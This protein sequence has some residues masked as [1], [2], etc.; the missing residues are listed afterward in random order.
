MLTY[1]CYVSVN[2]SS[3]IVVNKCSLCQQQVELMLYFIVMKNKLHDI[4]NRITALESQIFMLKRA[5]E[6]KTGKEFTYIERME[7]TI[8][9]LKQEL[10]GFHDITKTSN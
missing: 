4:R 7:E 1:K 5:L 2:D 10:A 9:Q 6:D 3:L 8:L